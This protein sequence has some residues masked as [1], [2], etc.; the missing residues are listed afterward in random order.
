MS[1]ADYIQAEHQSD[2]ACLMDV[3]ERFLDDQRRSWR[4]LIWALYTSNHIGHAEHIRSYAEP[5]KGGLTYKHKFSNHTMTLDALQLNSSSRLVHCLVIV[6][7]S[8]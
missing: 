1:I 4:E 7:L 2:E 8:S 5:L 6:G 3:V